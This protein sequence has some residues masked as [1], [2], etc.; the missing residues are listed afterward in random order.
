M[1]S[2]AA[3]ELRE[4]EV[5]P[6]AALVDSAVGQEALVAGHEAAVAL[7]VEAEE[8]PEGVGEASV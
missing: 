2:E 7:A 6:E 5:R 3:G 1:G 8:H 4:V